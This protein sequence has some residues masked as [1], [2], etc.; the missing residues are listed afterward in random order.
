MKNFS[1]YIGLM[2]AAVLLM[3]GLSGCGE[4][5]LT[6]DTDESVKH[7]VYIIDKTLYAPV[8]DLK[9]LLEDSVT[10]CFEAEG[11]TIDIV[12]LD[13]TS[14]TMDSVTYERI[15]A[16]VPGFKRTENQKKSV[17]KAINAMDKVTPE[18]PEVNMVGAI[19]TA[20][21]Q[22]KSFADGGEKRLIIVASCISTVSPLDMTGGIAYINIQDIVS[23][24]IDQKEIPD[25]SGVVIDIYGLGYI[26]QGKG[27]ENLSG[28]EAENLK[29]LYTTLFQSAGAAEGDICIHTNAPN[30]TDESERPYVTPV[31]TTGTSNSIVSVNSEELQQDTTYNLDDTVLEFS[32]NTLHYKAGSAE[33]IAGDDEVRAVLSP[34]VNWW[35][36]NT[37][38][39]LLVFS[40][41][42]SAGS[43]EELEQL[44]Q[45]RADA[46]KNRL[47]DMGV[48][49][50]H[51]LTYSL[52][53]R[54]NPY[55]VVDVDENGN[56]IEEEGRKNRVTY[57][58]SSDNECAD[59]FYEAINAE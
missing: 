34:V 27:Q 19:K 10:D 45:E 26:S 13:G 25:L 32:E 35:N 48:S 9:A 8:Y 4:N 22:L 42:A 53:Y 58:T 51:I 43:D 24:L 29:S 46:V 33:F 37:E 7:A 54:H 12:T 1:K 20:V 50:D 41:T 39:S 59:V 36:M 44:S 14:G 56:F 11:N 57:I 18:A 47:I 55:R 23:R 28:V 40:A 31:P 16:W 17:R 3:G 15:E 49:N 5:R 52:G 38:K 2:I 6:D 30:G 21:N